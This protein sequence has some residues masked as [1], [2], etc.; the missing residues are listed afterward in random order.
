MGNNGYEL[1]FI[2]LGG[3][4]FFDEEEE[5]ENF[6]VYTFS[7]QYNH[8]NISHEHDFYFFQRLLSYDL[9]FKI[10]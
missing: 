7:K 1:W 3:F 4:F 10:I 2:K 6:E 9:I 5:E 8:R